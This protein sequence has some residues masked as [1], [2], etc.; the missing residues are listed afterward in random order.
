MLRWTYT[1]QKN[2]FDAIV[3]QTPK[4]I[5]HKELTSYYYD[6]VGKKDLLTA[7]GIEYEISDT[8]Q[9]KANACFDDIA[10][11]CHSLL[12]N[13][14]RSWLKDRGVTDE[15]IVKH[16]IGTNIGYNPF[17]LILAHQK[18]HDANYYFY[19]PLIE[20]EPVKEY[21]NKENMFVVTFPFYNEKN[22]FTNLCCRILDNDFTEVFKF[23]FSHGNT[24]LFN[25]N[26][27]DLSK[28]FLVV[29]G[30]FDTLAADRYGI[31]SVAIGGSR[32][33]KYQT[34]LLL[35]YKDKAIVCLDGDIAGKYGMELVNGLFDTFKLPQDYDV[36]DILKE[37]PSYAG[38]LHTR[39]CK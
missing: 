31:P 37:D 12:E 29:E 33:S 27:I 4:D 11:Y 39:L 21:Y 1:N 10:S 20:I 38:I 19:P 28:P 34:E 8:L 9:K 22:Q 18:Q 24:S 23:F 17:K 3:E 13:T 30:V 2:I 35:P 36:D 7:A 16:K 15:Q 26:H 6:E 5:I 25:M 32:L 14:S